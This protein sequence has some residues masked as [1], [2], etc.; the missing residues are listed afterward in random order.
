MKA[1]CDN[2]VIHKFCAFDLFDDALSGIGVAHADVLVL[3]TAK[4]KF[5]SKAPAKGQQKYGAPVFARIQEAL[6]KVGEITTSVHLDDEKTLAA[7]MGIDQGEALLFSFAS[8]EESL[9]LTGDKRSLMALASESSCREIAAR[10]EGRVICLEQMVQHAIAFA[11]FSV[12]REK[13]VS[14][15]SAD[16]VVQVAFGSGLAT[17]QDAA[18]RALEYYVDDLRKQTGGL[19]RS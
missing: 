16:K 12:A 7:V 18:M 10:L 19:L 13:M 1:F 8:R 17:E 14:A 9:L 5:L 3:P 6:A 2:D 4:F 11:G 15:L